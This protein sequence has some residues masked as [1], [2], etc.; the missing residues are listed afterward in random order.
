[1]GTYFPKQ[2]EIARKWYVV[3]A[4]GETLGRLAARVARILIGKENPKYTPFLDAGDHVIVI[5][6]DKVR[7]TGMKTEQKL[8]HHYTGYPGGIRSEGFRKRFGRKPESVVQDAIV[9]MLPHTK[10]GR[11][12]A[13]KLKVY[14]GDKHPHQAQKPEAATVTRHRA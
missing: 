12:M 10:L 5:N 2:G 11:A 7:V 3:D 1:M 9:G 8:Y 6:A 13:R 14:R 4:T